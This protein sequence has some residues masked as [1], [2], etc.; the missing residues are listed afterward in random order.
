MDTKTNQEPRAQWEQW[1]EEQNES[2]SKS[3]GWLTVSSLSWLTDEPHTVDAFPGTWSFDGEYVHATFEEGDGV[4]LNG[5]PAVGE[6]EIRP[7]ED[8][9]P[10]FTKGAKIMEIAPRGGRVI[11]RVRDDEAALRKSFSGVPTYDYDPEWVVPVDYKPYEEPRDRDILTA[12]EGFTRKM[13][14]S[15]EAEM[16]LGD[17]TYNMCVTDSDEPFV[18]FTDKTSGKESAGWRSTPLRKTDDGWV[19]DFNY[20][21]NFPAH[22]TPFGVCPRPVAENMLDVAIPAGQ[23][24]P[25]ETYD[26]VN[27]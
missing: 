24:K 1:R 15:G 5:E 8:P 22:Y 18:I 9:M 2:L 19:I 12:Q 25:N 20:S 6:F 23:Q 27:K 10:E 16:K 21:T 14:F 11:L 4:T 7:D 17:E 26:S 3:H 13:A